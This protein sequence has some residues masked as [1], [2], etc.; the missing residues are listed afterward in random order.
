MAF[1]LTEKKKSFKKLGQDQRNASDTLLYPSTTSQVS[2]Q[3]VLME[4]LRKTKSI[5]IYIVL[6][7]NAICYICVYTRI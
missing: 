1:L 3:M 7:M 2:S 4:E 5:H 6:N